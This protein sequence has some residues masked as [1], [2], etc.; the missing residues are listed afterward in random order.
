MSGWN[1]GE[2]PTRNNHYRPRSDQNLRHREI[3][4]P[5]QR[6][7]TPVLS[8]SRLDLCALTEFVGISY[9]FDTAKFKPVVNSSSSG[10][11]SV[12]WQSHADS[13]LF[14][15][16]CNDIDVV[17]IT[18]AVRRLSVRHCRNDRGDSR[19][20]IKT[21]GRIT[22]ELDQIRPETVGVGQPVPHASAQIR[23][24]LQGHVAALNYVTFGN[25]RIH[26]V[27]RYV[28]TA[29]SGQNSDDL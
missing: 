16:L 7:A 5:D 29:L 18:L 6:H 28:A 15:E 12:R 3:P 23:N 9:R 13:S 26:G 14:R 11:L 21:E 10:I 27:R 2:W 17:Q 1:R 22:G 25:K 4:S 20:I 19:K 24:Q 8:S